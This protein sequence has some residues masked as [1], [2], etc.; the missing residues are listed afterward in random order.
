MTENKSVNHFFERPF[1]SSF[2]FPES[3]G[4]N[5][6]TSTYP[7]PI[8]FKDYKQIILQIQIDISI[9]KE[10]KIIVKKV[11]FYYNVD[12]II[13]ETL[14]TI[15]KKLENTDNLAGLQSLLRD[16]SKKFVL[17]FNLYEEYIFGDY[18]IGT[19][20]TI[21]KSIREFEPINLI[22]KV[23]DKSIVSPKL[24]HY[25]PII[26]MSV[27]K[28]YNYLKLIKKYFKKYQDE[29]IVFRFKPSK[30]LK[31]KFLLI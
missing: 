11:G 1:S 27:E 29:S 22:L 6:F 24:S 23:V 2:L 9:S 21:R 26:Y 8:K 10:V 4:I 19:Y 3:L 28:K 13:K 12:T 17:K 30:A 18:P 7:I 15:L 14:R 31:S 16:S 25:P 5:N 20:E